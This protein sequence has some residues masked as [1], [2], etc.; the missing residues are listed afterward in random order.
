MSLRR[1]EEVG[2]KR[3]TTGQ[4]GSVLQVIGRPWTADTSLRLEK[5]VMLS[6]P[7]TTMRRSQVP[8]NSTTWWSLTIQY[9][10]RNELRALVLP[11]WCVVRAG[12]IPCFPAWLPPRHWCWES[13]GLAIHLAWCYIA[14]LQ[15]WRS[16]PT[17]LSF[18]FSISKMT[19]ITLTTSQSG[20]EDWKRLTAI[21]SCLGSMIK[22][23]H[24]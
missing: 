17:P 20:C 19:I 13:F 16:Y 21:R 9:W 4:Q 10:E 22:Y 1:Q 11:L 12:T 2:Y 8:Q 7:P 5:A 23:A 14:V 3:V 6:G 15:P 24:P 18:C